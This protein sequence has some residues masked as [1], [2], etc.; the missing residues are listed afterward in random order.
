M[1]LRYILVFAAI[2]GVLGGCAKKDAN[3]PSSPNTSTEGKLRFAVIPKGMTHEYWK[4]VHAGADDAAK[5]LGVEIIWKGPPTESD[6]MSQ[7]DTVANFV[8]D[9]VSGIVLAPL[10][11]KVLGDAVEEAKQ[12][13]IPVVIIDS[14]LADEFKDSYVSFIATDNEKGGEIAGQ[15]MVELLK[16][17]GRVIMM[18]YQPNSASTDLREEGFLKVMKATP[19]ITMVSDNQYGNATKESAAKTGETLLA[20]FMKPD[21]SFGADG[22]FCP[23]ESTTYGMLTVLQQSNLAGKVKF[24][25]FDSSDELIKALEKSSIN[26]LVVQ[27]P[28]KMGYDGVKTLYKSIKGQKVEKTYDTGA[29]MVTPENMKQPENDKLLKPKRL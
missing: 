16:G 8:N 26:G 3:N 14:G 13:G 9:K 25:G 22:I 18:R 17:K 1:K 4:A 21:G 11:N 7:K 6:R 24:V 2:L 12:A 19:G 10:D 15:R 28:Y 20:R 27:N 5:E 23:N 29:T